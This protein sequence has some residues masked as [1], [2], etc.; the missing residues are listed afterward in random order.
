MFQTSLKIDDAVSG[1]VLHCLRSGT[2]RNDTA[3]K[4]LLQDGKKE[5][6]AAMHHTPPQSPAGIPNQLRDT[7]RLCHVTS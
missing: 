6:R 1:D 7:Y 3:N 2:C 5:Y 4:L